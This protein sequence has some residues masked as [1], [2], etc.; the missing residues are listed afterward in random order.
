MTVPNATFSAFAD[1]G[2]LQ[3]T[4]VVVGLR[5]GIN[6]RFKATAFPGLYLPLAG[7]TM[8]GAINMNTSSIT[9]LPLPTLST[10]AASKAYVDSKT[11]S[12]GAAGTFQRSNGTAWV[13]SSSTIPD[14]Y[15]LGDIIYGSASNVLTALAGNTTTAKQYLSQTGTGVASAAPA[16][17][18]ISGSD[19]TGAALTKTDDTN[20]TLT[21]GG[22]AS[23]ALLRAASL[24]LGW[25]GNLAVGRGGTGNTTFTAYS[26]IC[27]GTTAT[28]A[29]QNVSGVGTL[30]QVLVSQG[31]GALPQWGSVPGVTP[32]ALTEVNDTNV[33]MTL[34]GTPTTALLQA[35]SM[36]LGWTGQLS[37]ARGGSNA[38]LTAVNG[39]IVYSTASAMAISAAGAAG[40]ILQSAGAATPVWTTATYPATAGTSGNYLKSD[41]TN[42][43]SASPAAL[44]KTD[45]TNV[46]LTL[47]GSPTVALLAAASLTLGWTGNLA[48]GRGGTGNTTFTAYSVLCAGTTAT[49]AFQNVSG[50]GSTGQVLTSQGAGALPQWANAPG[51]GTI[52]SGLINQLAYYAAAGTTLSGL[53]GGNNLLLT[54]NGSGVPTWV[55]SITNTN[56]GVTM[57]QKKG[58]AGGDY[59]TSSSTYV[60]IDATNLK[61]VVT[62]PTGYKLDIKAVASGNNTTDSLDGLAIAD[63]GTV[64][65]QSIANN[66][67]SG[68]TM[69]CLAQIT[70][71]G[72][73]HT[74]TLQ[75]KCSAS[76]LT[77]YN[78][79]SSLT[80]FMTFILMPSN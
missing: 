3:T 15:N 71:D 13:A 24:T 32:A 30:N 51:T 68:K 35:V 61:Y 41:G 75:F 40:Q 5:N 27:A 26:L 69:S 57:T 16:W 14:T 58:S 78:S 52:N 20:V 42:W 55:S 2:D 76:T 50:V 38:N 72:A 70:G 11:A 28:G 21:L 73:S 8:T 45:D 6:T 29:F 64:V 47:G 17:A 77:L 80:P 43:T 22:S 36:T 1:G 9:G 23:T 25:T 49:G 31:A 66:Q 19:I 33:T 34:G 48:V 65:M 63:G 54:T 60:D 4:D 74:I 18:T 7:G 79:T 56:N 44:T 62:I 46:T 37:L 67:G 39:G 53:T 12:V 59:T 10:D